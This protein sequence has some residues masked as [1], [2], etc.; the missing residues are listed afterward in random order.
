MSGQRDKFMTFETFAEQ[1]QVKG[2]TPRECSYGHWQIRGGKFC[3]NFYPFKDGG[4]SFYINGMNSGSRHRI[5]LA[6]AI[7]AANNPPVSKLH[8]RT[9]ERKRSYK[10]VKRRLL[11]V[12]PFCYWCKKPLD[13]TSATLDHVIPLSKGGTNGA[14]NFVLACDGCNHDRRNDMPARTKWENLSEFPLTFI[15]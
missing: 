13:L 8:I 3:V 9:R 4:P 15:L 5:T 2:L 7:V 11:R 14:D 10:G 6:V 12:S 1:V